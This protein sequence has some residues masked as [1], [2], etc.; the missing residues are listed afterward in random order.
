MSKKEQIIEEISKT[1][2]TLGLRTVSAVPSPILG[3]AGNREFFL[4]LR[5]HLVP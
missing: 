3:A 1:A 5:A 4:H 2:I